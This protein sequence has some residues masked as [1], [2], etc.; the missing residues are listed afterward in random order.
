MLGPT[1]IEDDPGPFELASPEKV[2]A[3]GPVLVIFPESGNIDVVLVEV[4]PLDVHHRER[5][6]LDVHAMTHLSNVLSLED[7]RPKG[8][9][10]LS[11]PLCEERLRVG[12]IC[13]SPWCYKSKC[14][15][16]NG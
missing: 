16:H 1:S 9:N 13:D 14:G 10:L 11:V 15:D 4:S 12:V 5:L 2:A 3:F 8:Y 7:M 6:R